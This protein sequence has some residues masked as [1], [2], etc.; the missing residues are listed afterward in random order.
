MPQKHKQHNN[1]KLKQIFQIKFPHTSQDTIKPKY[2]SI[3]KIKP[4]NGGSIFSLGNACAALVITQTSPCSFLATPQTNPFL[5][6]R[7][8]YPDQNK[9]HRDAVIFILVGT[10]GLP[11]AKPCGAFVWCSPRNARQTPTHCRPH[12][13]ARLSRVLRP[14]S[15]AK[16]LTAKRRFNL[17]VGTQGLE[18]WTQ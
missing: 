1:T 14:G 18:P 5:G 3:Q 7:L 15:T 6:S 8:A 9:K 4:P 12:A 2:R 17:L 11:R 16:N 13:A 10:Q